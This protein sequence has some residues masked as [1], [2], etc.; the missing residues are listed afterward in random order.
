MGTL[1]STISV[2]SM[3]H[4]IL[5]RQSGHGLKVRAVNMTISRKTSTFAAPVMGFRRSFGRS[6][7]AADQERLF[8]ILTLDKRGD[9]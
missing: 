5:I 1:D 3:R 7:N 9:Q 6:V 8:E 4:V 2:S